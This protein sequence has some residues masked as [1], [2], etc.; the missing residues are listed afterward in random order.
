MYIH[1]GDDGGDGGG[2]RWVEEGGTRWVG[3]VEDA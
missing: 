1:I 2:T 3:S